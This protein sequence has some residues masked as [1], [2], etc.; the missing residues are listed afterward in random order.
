MRKI[1]SE[2]VAHAPPQSPSTDAPST[3]APSTDAP[4]TDAPSTD[5]SSGRSIPAQ[6]TRRRSTKPGGSGTCRRRR[7]SRRM[8]EGVPA[9]ARA[10][11]ALHT[12]LRTVPIEW[13]PRGG[14]D[15]T[16]RLASEEGSIRADTGETEQRG[17]GRMRPRYASDEDR[18]RN[19]WTGHPPRWPASADEHRICRLRPRSVHCSSSV[20]SPASF[21][22]PQNTTI[23][24]SMCAPM[25]YQIC[26]GTPCSTN[27]PYSD[28]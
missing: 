17:K 3:D 28:V 22:N 16:R 6:A 19:R 26:W 4:S 9:R 7:S 10:R 25:V 2:F 21:A 14:S 12:G 20:N 23:A 11:V 24:T 1:T 18:P 27:E 5:A 8:G 13:R 15:G